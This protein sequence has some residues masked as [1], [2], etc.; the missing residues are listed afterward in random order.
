MA[1]EFKSMFLKR[2]FIEGLA[3]ASYLVGDAGEAVVVDPKRD[4]DDYIADAQASGLRIVA[5]LNT[6]PHADF[7]SGFRE[8]AARTGAKI[9]MSH[10]APTRYERVSARD[11]Q[12]V[13]IGSLEIEILQ[14]PGHSPDSLS[15]LVREQGQPVAVFTGDLLFVNDVGR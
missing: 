12:R 4:V 3:H 8:L 13:P 15:F 10:L 7:A 14:T 6:H 2:Y 1:E 11:G 5:V 9:Y